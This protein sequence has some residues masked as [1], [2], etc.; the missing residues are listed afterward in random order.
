MKKNCDFDKRVRAKRYQQSF[1]SCEQASAGHQ[2]TKHCRYPA[3]APAP[4]SLSPAAVPHQAHSKQE[5]AITSLH[6]HRTSHR[7]DTTITFIY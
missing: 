4:A 6:K 2:G 3:P 1:V 7:R 5:R